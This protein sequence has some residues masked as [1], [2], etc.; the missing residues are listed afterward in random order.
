MIEGV[1]RATPGRLSSG[2]RLLITHNSLTDLPR[3]LQLM[4]SLGLE[5]RVLAA[6]H[7]PFRPFINRGWL[8][9]LGGVQRGLYTVRDGQA[10]ETIHVVEAHVQE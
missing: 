2:G 5:S 8:D 9:E 7:L 4:Q 10:Y 6:R 3:S 1:I